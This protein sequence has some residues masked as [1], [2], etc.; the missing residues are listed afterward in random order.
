MYA[1]AYTYL[2][3]TLVVYVAMDTLLR[4]Y[5]TIA[6]FMVGRGM[7]DLEKIILRKGVSVVCTHTLYCVCTYM[8]MFMFTCMRMYSR[9]YVSACVRALLILHNVKPSDLCST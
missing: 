1:C 4:Y 8:C 2:V 7:C 3:Y 9:V 6:Y 5:V